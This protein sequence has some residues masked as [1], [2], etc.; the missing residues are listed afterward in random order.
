[1]L[2]SGFLATAQGFDE[3]MRERIS[4]HRASRGSSWR[5]LE[6]F[7][8][9]WDV[10]GSECRVV[11]LDCLTLWLNNLMLCERDV[12]ADLGR[13]VA[14]RPRESPLRVGGLVMG[15]ATSRMVG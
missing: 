10:I 8:E 7:V 12:A 15:G 11:V 3:E 4:R 6:G 9:I 14:G 5:T 13:L 1:M 2:G